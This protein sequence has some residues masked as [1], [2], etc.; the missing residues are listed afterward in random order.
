MVSTREVIVS[1]W[2]AWRL[3]RLD[4]GGL[5]CFEAT[6]EG[7]RRSFWAAALVAPFYAVMVAAGYP[8]HRAGG[9][10]FV[11]AESIAYVVTWVAYP[12]VAEWLSR[13][14]GCRDRFEGYLAAYN[15]S[16]V[17]QHAVVLPIGILAMLG[18]LPSGAAEGLWLI[19]FLL[20]LVYLFFIARTALAV[21]PTT[22]AGLVML[23]V[24]LSALIDGIAAGMS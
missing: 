17:V 3:A 19:A 13:R 18:A 9:W 15:W 5:A 14:L 2:G 6:T 24:L 1:L 21:L 10:R 7:A 4:R 11:L 12:V 8:A 23:D 16:M 20:I 22:A